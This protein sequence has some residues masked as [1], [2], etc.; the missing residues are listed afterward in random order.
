MIIILNRI[1]CQYPIFYF[2][3]LKQ[4]HLQ[5]YFIKLAYD[6]SSF[7][8]WQ[9]QPREVNIQD[10]L[11]D[12]ISLI[13]KVESAKLVGC[14]RTDTGVHASCYYA[15]FDLES[16]ILDINKTIYKLNNYL[17]HSVAIL[18]LFAVSPD[19]HAR[20]DATI[21]TYNYFIHQE[22]NP[23]SN[24]YSLL[25]LRELDTN[26]MNL[27]AKI[28]LNHSDFS[29]FSKIG[30][31]NKSTLC[32]VI[33]AKWEV[34]DK[35]IK[36]TIS[37]DRFLRN[38]VRAIVGTMLEVGLGKISVEDFEM[39]IKS[40]SRQNAGASAPAHALFLSNIKYPF[41]SV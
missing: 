4:T 28:L 40:G 22:K 16:P 7:F 11:T 41:I 34:S 37:A 13:L 21:R 12:A 29:A 18:D 30:S 24:K 26:K 23:F 36:F 39:V 2:C 35:Q 10:A 8:G 19:A 15:H 3:P 38:M 33:E 5:R 25:F 1:V 27:A 6:G 14:G 17:A 20:F 31:D 9:T 32:K